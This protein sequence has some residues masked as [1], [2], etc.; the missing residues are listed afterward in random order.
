MCN[1]GDMKSRVTIVAFMMFTV[2]SLGLSSNTAYAGIDFPEPP[3]PPFLQDFVHAG[4][5]CEFEV[6]PENF[7]FI[8]D[9]VTN[10]PTSEF[11]ADTD[12]WPL[13]TTEPQFMSNM[14]CDPVV[15]DVTKCTFDIANL[16]D[17][18]EFKIIEI[19]IE[20]DTAP[21]VNQPTIG[22]VT[23]FADLGP[24]PSCQ[25]LNDNGPGIIPVFDDQAPFDQIGEALVYF[26]GCE[27]NPDWERIVINNI[28]TDVFFVD[29]WTQ[30]FDVPPPVVGGTFV[31]IDNTALI[32]AGAQSISMWMIPVVIAGIGI[33][34]FVI[35][36]RN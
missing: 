31:P 3:N 29:F 21:L 32:L 19:Q 33:A 24:T 18:L 13:Y 25:T 27:P 34:I 11:D 17:T 12:P 30:T 4:W 1:A 26:I 9:N 15:N 22:P 36:R 20:Y 8:C 23:A 14:D 28:G 7:I 10:V 6:A 16:V 35:K 5:T 2:L